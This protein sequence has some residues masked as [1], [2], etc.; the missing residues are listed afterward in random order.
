[1]T[2]PTTHQVVNE[3]GKASDRQTWAVCRQIISLGTSNC[4]PSG[5][6]QTNLKSLLDFDDTDDDTDAPAILE[7]GEDSDGE[8]SVPPVAAEAGRAGII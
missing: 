3:H 6:I 8:E 7:D 5:G 4:R 1:M 2:E